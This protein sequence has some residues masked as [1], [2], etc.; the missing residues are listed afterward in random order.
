MTI[1][2]LEKKYI[3]NFRAGR[4]NNPVPGFDVSFGW[5][6]PDPLS[7]A[8]HH[9]GEDHA[10]PE[11]TPVVAVTW[12]HVV[13][14]GW[15]GAPHDWGSPYGNV[16]LIEQDGHWFLG[17]DVRMG[18]PDRFAVQGNRRAGDDAEQSDE[19]EKGPSGCRDGPARKESFTHA[20]H[21][22]H[23][24]VFGLI[25]DLGRHGGQPALLGDPLDFAPRHGPDEIR[26]VFQ[27]PF[28]IR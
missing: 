1:T 28:R 21:E 20:L 4:I 6:V 3:A 11:G 12:G 8:G 24:L 19:Q 7:Q 15:G 25:H 2:K 14:A 16:V 22:L 5:H 13:G 18:R 17:D 26:N 23:E 27:P 10:C 9:T